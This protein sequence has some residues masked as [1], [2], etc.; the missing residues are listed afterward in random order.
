MADGPL[1]LYARGELALPLAA[2][3]AVLEGED[4]A[5]LEA[6]V[7]AA[8]A[9]WG[10]AALAPLLARLG[11]EAAERV[12]RVA[13]SVDH[14]A[15][16][17]TPEAALAR[18]S[19]EFDRAAAVSPD[20]GVA[21]YSLGDPDL[22]AEVTAEVAAWLRAER[23]LRPGDRLLEVG[24]GAGRHLRALACGPGAASSALGV[25]LSRAMAQ[26]A[27]RR[28]CDLPHVRV[29]QGSGRD[30]AF[31]ADAGVDLVL[32]ADSFPYVVQAGGDLPA[33]HL[34]EAARVLRPG[35]RLCVLNWSYGGDREA[36]VR[37]A[38][39]LAAD[40]GLTAAAPGAPAFRSWDALALSF[41]K[42]GPGA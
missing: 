3:R 41:T 9:R 31:V 26:E 18:Q 23:L 5:G 19:A 28:L 16:D 21:L 29:V 34:A 37:Q 30:L 14:A 35:G 38:A 39:R 17:A 40:A 22:L 6:A 12:R 33:R 8:R 36:D 4:A 24:C 15:R 7:A 20:A 2:M 27:A 42:A 32:Y 25:E 11:P 1:D 13:A 10:A